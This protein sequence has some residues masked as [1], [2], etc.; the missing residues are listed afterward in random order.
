MEHR[1]ASRSTFWEEAQGRA[2]ARSPGRRQ[3]EVDAG[4][5][6]GLTSE[7]RA[8]L[9]GLRRQVR[10]LEGERQILRARV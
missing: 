10:V 5:P 3:A 2:P 7:D 1:R 9:V 6:S 4:D 8:E